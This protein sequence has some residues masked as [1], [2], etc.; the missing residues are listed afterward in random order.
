MMRTDG[1]L[2]AGPIKLLI[3]DVDGTLVTPDKLITK[4]ALAAVKALSSAG[5]G[6]SIVSA[7][8]PRGLAK[9][10]AALDLQ[11]PY[12]AF[13]GGSLIGSDGNLIAAERLP[14][15]AARTILQR[16]GEREIS[17]WVF[18]D[19]NWRLKDPGGPQ[20]WRERRTVGF[21]PVV[22]PDFEDVVGQ[23]D[24]IVGVSE[25]PALLSA[26]EAEAQSWVDGRAIVQ[27]SQA[28]YLDFTALL[29][30]KGHAVEAICRSVGVAP[31]ETAVIGDMTN[32]VAMF[33]TAG[34]SIA[35]GQ[36]PNAVKA[37]AHAVT[38]ANTD[39]GFAAAVE[40]LL[41]ARVARP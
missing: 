32:D 8:P 2:P 12:A 34:F 29:A 40:Q 39:E 26:I 9:V 21:A 10:A 41:L 5:V 4:R 18:A 1:V 6:F 15:D 13:N 33:R 19:D 24:K 14:L 28:Y 11:L 20:V 36:A 25:D 17:T 35:M 27:R 16:L 37:Q 7:R 30:N 23:I 22:T 38:K 31:E 3:S